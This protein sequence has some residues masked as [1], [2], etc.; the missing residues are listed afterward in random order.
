MQT[1]FREGEGGREKEGGMQVEQNHRLRYKN[2][3][4]MD[5]I[6]KDLD[7]RTLTS[8]G[9]NV[10]AAPS[11]LAMASPAELGRSAKTTD[12]PW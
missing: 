1:V 11:S 3:D 6:N 9:T 2:R 12:A 5:V 8:A 4:P 7:K 10:V